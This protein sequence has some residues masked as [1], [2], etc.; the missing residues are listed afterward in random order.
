[1]A[2]QHLDFGTG[3]DNDGEYL[4]PAMVKVQS[5]FTE[6]YA[7]ALACALRAAE[8]YGPGV[9]GDG[10]MFT[11]LLNSVDTINTGASSGYEFKRGGIRAAI[12][13]ANAVNVASGAVSGDNSGWSGNTIVVSVQSA[14]IANTGKP[15]V[16]VT[17]R[18]GSGG[19][20]TI[21]GAFIGVIDSNG[22]SFKKDYPVKRLRFASGTSGSATATANNTIVSDIEEYVVPAGQIL[23][24]SFYVSSGGFFG[25]K[26]QTGWETNYKAAT[27]EPGKFTKTGYSETATVLG[28]ETVEALDAQSANMTLRSA[29]LPLSGS[30]ASVDV[31]VP[32]EIGTGDLSDLAFAVS[33]D[34]T[35]WQAITLTNLFS[36]NGVKHLVAENVAL[37][38][39]GT[40][41]ALYWRMVTTNN[42]AV[43][44]KGVGICTDRIF[45]D[46]PTTAMQGAIQ[47]TYHTEATGLGY[48]SGGSVAYGRLFGFT[49]DWEIKGPTRFRINLSMQLEHM[50]GA[51]A[52]SPVAYSIPVTAIYAEE[53]ADFGAK[54]IIEDDTD[55]TGNDVE[56]WIWHDAGN[57]ANI[58]EHYKSPS[59]EVVLDVEDPGAIRFEVWGYSATAVDSPLVPD[60]IAVYFNES[61]GFGHKGRPNKLQITSEPLR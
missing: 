18:A 19:S 27:D 1:M 56:K 24:V 2:Q 13:A 47:T 16:R 36:T 32:V 23:G 14:N 45:T 54:P 44:P 55:S 61:V 43:F 21:N 40:G 15:Y 28:L 33:R 59:V 26:L 34:A 11:D 12:A 41:S 22:Y 49:Q 46:V 20:L 25:T 53:I 42:K 38:A 60:R 30:P 57:I 37:S 58:D 8:R 5:N 9:S 29:Q 52:S 50:G 31:V 17:W 35:T 39:A 4:R 48:D 51:V 10:A 3:A 7:T 6:L